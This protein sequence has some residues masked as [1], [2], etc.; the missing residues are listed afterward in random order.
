MNTPPNNPVIPLPVTNTP[1][2]FN[3]PIRLHETKLQSF[4]TYPLLHIHR[5]DV[6]FDGVALKISDSLLFCP[7]KSHCEKRMLIIF[8]CHV[9][10]FVWFVVL[11]PCLPCILVVIRKYWFLLVACGVGKYSILGVAVCVG[12]LSWSGWEIVWLGKDRG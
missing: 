12:E 5:V 7:K 4:N 6:P 8:C 10:M 2:L 3:P 1:N 9:S 11:L